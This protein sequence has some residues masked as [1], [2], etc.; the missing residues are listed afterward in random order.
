MNKINIK[1]LSVNA[2]WQGRRFKTPTYKAYEEELLHMLPK[3]I[4]CPV[5]RLFLQITVGVSNKASD[6]DNIVKPFVDVLQKKYGFDDKR[7]YGMDL[8]KEDV[9]KGDEFISFELTALD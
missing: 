8:W 4:K 6:L 1:P 5:G 7:I 3:G 2:C 9:K